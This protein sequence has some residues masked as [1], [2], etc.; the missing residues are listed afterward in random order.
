MSLPFRYDNL[1][2]RYA[3]VRPWAEKAVGANINRCA[4]CMAYTL[5]ISPSPG[6]T[7]IADLPSDKAKFAAAGPVKH[8]PSLTGPRMGGKA[9]GTY[10]GLFFIRATE[11]FQRVQR[12][13]GQPDVQGRSDSVWRQVQG[14][15]GVIYLAN[16][17]QTEGD[18]KFSVIPWLYQPMSG[19]HWDLFDGFIM[20]AE[21]IA[22][23]G[24]THQGNLY[25]WNAR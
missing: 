8:G 1:T 9:G 5:Q 13:F 23:A 10:S 11:L 24:N 20:V 2:T 15:K 21:K 3:T 14:R 4:I 12:A 16:C 7:S 22:I 18:K 6:D 17:Y 25:F 19:G